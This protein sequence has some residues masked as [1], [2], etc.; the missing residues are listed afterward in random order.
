MGNPTN[1]CTV[2]PNGLVAFYNDPFPFNKVFVLNGDGA[3]MYNENSAN[4]V[5]GP[6][7]LV[8]SNVFNIAGTSLTLASNVIS[9]SGSLNK[10]GGGALLISDTN[11]FTGST[12]ISTG[13]VALVGSSSLSTSPNITLGIG[14]ILDVSTRTDGGL[15]LVGGQMLSGV[16]TIRGNL[17]NGVGATLSP[18]IGGVGIL[19]VTN[20]VSLQGTTI[21]DIASGTNDLITGASFINYGGALN[22]VFTPGSLVAGNSFKLFGAN[23]YAGSFATITPATPGANLAWDTSSLNSSGILGVKP[24]TNPNPTNI[25]ASV[26]GGNLNLS[27]PSDHL[28]WRLQAQTNSINTGLG[29]NWFDVVNTAGVTNIS[30]PVN[31]AAGAIFYRLVY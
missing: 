15:T 1:T 29:T 16:G 13:R 3:G 11:T 6:V 9:G 25:T 18:G 14:A 2:E 17:T 23:S 24:P 4:T 20:N 7:K 30:I 26:S 31:S 12:L 19:T 27:W 8:G 10:I 28:G 22:L 5:I 21:M